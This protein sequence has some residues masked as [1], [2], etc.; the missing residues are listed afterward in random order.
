MADNS[1]VVDPSSVETA[2]TA[3]SLLLVPV[4]VDIIEENKQ[5]G[6]LLSDLCRRLT[7]KN[8]NF[9]TSRE[10]KEAEDKLKQARSFFFE[11]QIVY[12]ALQDLSINQMANKNS[13]SKENKVFYKVT[14]RIRSAEICK[15]LED[16]QSEVKLLDL[17]PNFVMETT[18]RITEEEVKEIIIPKLEEFIIKKCKYVLEFYGI[19]TSDKLYSS[20]INQLPSLLE[21][22]TKNLERERGWLARDMVDVFP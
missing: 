1:K 8:G 15:Y 6:N 20:Q 14:E 5:F 13:D 21:A 10:E 16:V 12:D 19:E 17:T 11:Q 3:S 4:P 2:N 18:S 22:D 9:C 7:D